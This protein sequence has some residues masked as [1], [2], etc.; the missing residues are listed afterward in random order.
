[1]KQSD[2][3][4]IILVAVLGVGIAAWLCDSLLGNPDDE[5]VKYKTIEPVSGNLGVPDPDIFNINA[6]NPTVEVYVGTCIDADRDGVL[7]DAELAECHEIET[8]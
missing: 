4:S 1:M 2:I 5:V 3:I 8:E 7:S 6:I